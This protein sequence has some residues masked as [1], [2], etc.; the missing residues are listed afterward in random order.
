MDYVI[1]GGGLA[2]LLVARDI[3]AHAPHSQVTILEAKHRGG[4]RM[5]THTLEDLGAEFIQPG[6]QPLMLEELSRYGIGLEEGGEGG[7][8]STTVDDKNTSW[9]PP[10]SPLLSPLFAAIDHDALSRVPTTSLFTPEV[11]DLDVPL[12]QYLRRHCSEESLVRSVEHHF[13]PFSG[14]HSA[15]VS[16]L[17][18]LR[19]VRQFGGCLL[20]FTAGEARVQGGVQTLPT[21]IAASLPPGTLR[22]GCTATKV[23]ALNDGTVIV[24]YSSEEGAARGV[25]KVA[26]T[27]C[28]VA[29][30]FNALWRVEFVGL[31]SLEFTARMADASRVGHAGKVYKYHLP[32]PPSLKTLLEG[33]EGS[34]PHTLEYESRQ[35]SNQ[36]VISLDPP[37]TVTHHHHHHHNWVGD[38]DIQGTWMAPR[39]GQLKVLEELRSYQGGGVWFGGADLSLHW[40]GWMEGAIVSARTLCARVTGGGT[41]FSIFNSTGEGV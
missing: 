10:T 37:P 33:E 16:A 8:P 19:E 30:P 12:G 32:A 9:E 17:S 39:V 24:H 7:I 22:L 6:V 23:E 2:G 5:Y 25:E 26:C 3:L 28:I 14:A 41:T 11:E 15:E 20:M 4:G 38:A 35:G 27:Q 31:S 18:M 40:P 1:L 21:A 13:F 34:D 29:L 36:V